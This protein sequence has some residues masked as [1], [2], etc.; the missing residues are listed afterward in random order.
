MIMKRLA[1]LIITIM[2]LTACNKKAEQ[3]DSLAALNTAERVKEVWVKQTKPLEIEVVDRTKEELQAIGSIAVWLND[4]EAATEFSFDGETFKPATEILVDSAAGVRIGYPF[5]EGAHVGDTI[6]VSQSIGHLMTGKYVQTRNQEVKIMMQF[7]MEDIAALLRIRLK[8]DNIE[9]ILNSITILGMTQIHD[10]VNY[11]NGVMEVSA[12]YGGLSSLSNCALNNGMPHDFYLFPVSESCD[13]RI[14]VAVGAQISRVT[15]KI[16]PL[17][18]GSITELYLVLNNGK[19]SV[20][21]SWVDTKYAF[22]Q[23]KTAVPDSI[24]VGNFLQKNGSISTVYNEES[25]AM[26]IE[27]TGKHGKAVAL[28]D[29]DS[30]R[31]FGRKQFRTGQLFETVDGKNREGCFYSKVKEEGEEQIQFAP[32]VV[33][34]PRS[35]FGERDGAELTMK[36]LDN[37]SEETRL[38]FSEAAGHG[39]A[40]IPSLL[41][42]ATLAQELMVYA[43]NLPEEFVAP[44]GYY[45]SSCESGS[46]TFYALNPQTFRISAYN[47]KEY[48]NTQTRLF[49]LF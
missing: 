31:P 16:P 4:E 46:D 17:R 48:P 3:Q 6:R 39:T 1:L 10:V 25:I 18:A 28:V 42:L 41:E 40:Y 23:Q 20:G 33:Y 27:T 29:N 47:S 2:T 34:S 12:S 49:Y 37:C 21:S 38:K 7:E 44:E 43:D 14:E 8:S 11:D 45:L 30:I 26:V 15:T 22:E 24:R 13:I 32:K 5:R 9:D 35:A 36:L 19:L